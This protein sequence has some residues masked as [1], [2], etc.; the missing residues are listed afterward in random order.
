MPSAPPNSEQV[1]EI[2]EAAPARGWILSSQAATGELRYERNVDFQDGDMLWDAAA[3]NDGRLLAVGSS[4]YTQNPSGL[5]VSDARDPLALVLDALGN[6]EKRIALPAGPAGRGNEA[7]SVS[8]GDQDQVAISGVQNAPG[9]H[10][11]VF[12]DAFL[13]VRGP[14]PLLTTRP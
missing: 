5:S 11:A 9:T 4:N 8:L 6:V 14:E 10:A 7:M 2:A 1:S 3:L 12:S 13:L